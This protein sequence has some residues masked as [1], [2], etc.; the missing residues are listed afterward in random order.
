MKIRRRILIAYAVLVFAI[1]GPNAIASQ[2]P[3]SL[4]S[5]A[6]AFGVLMATAAACNLPTAPVEAAMDRILAKP[7]PL[8]PKLPG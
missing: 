7:R 4:D 3:D 1:S 2:E 8:R 6:L 5:V